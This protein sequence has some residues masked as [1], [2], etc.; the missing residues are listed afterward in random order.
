DA[1]VTRF[2]ALLAGFA[3]LLTR[4]TN[5]EEVVVGTPTAG[6][7]AP[8]SRDRL[9]YFVNPVPL[10]ITVPPGISFR[11]LTER[12]RGAVLDALDHAVPFPR[13]VEAVQPV[14]DPGRP[15]LTQAMLV[16]HQPP[17]G[18]PD[19]GGLAVADETAQTDLGGLLVRPLRLAASDSPFDLSLILAEVAGGLSGVVEY[20][21]DLFDAPAVSN[22][23]SHLTT[24]LAAV[25][26]SPDVPLETVNPLDHEARKRVLAIGDRGT[27]PYPD[28]TTVHALFS[29]QAARSP[30]AVAVVSGA[31]TMNYS[32]LDRRSGQVAALLRDRFG[33]TR[34]D[35]VAVLL[36]RDDPDLIVTFWGILKAGAAY[37]PLDPQLP[38]NRLEWLLSDASPAT[39]V[40]DATLADR[41]PDG[42]GPV[43]CRL[44]DVDW[45]GVDPAAAD[46]S[47]AGPDDLAYV[48]YTSGSTGRP[49]GVQVPHRGVCNLAE[50]FATGFGISEFD[51]VLQYASCGFD[52]WILETLPAQLRGAALYLVQP[53]AVPPGPLLVE[54]LERERITAAILAPAV[55]AALPDTKLPHLN[56]LVS[57][58]DVCPTDVVDRWAPGRHFLNAYGPTE[59]TVCATTAV[60]QPERRRPPIGGPLDNVRLYVL[61]Q[62]MRPVPEGVPGELYIGG[63]GITWGYL[64][65]PGLTAERF[66]PDPFGETPGARLYRTGDRVR[67]L[68]DGVLDFLGRVDQQVKI[69]GVRIEP[70]E[71]ESRLMEVARPREV[72]VVA[73]DRPG[74]RVG[75]AVELVAYLVADP[76][77]PTVGELRALLR[78]ELP[79]PL[80]PSAFVYLD[81][82]PRAA[83]GKLDREALPAPTL[84]DR[85]VTASGAPR[86]DLERTVAEVWAAA[87]GHETVGLRDHFFDELGGSS[88]LVAKV[89]AELSRRLGRDVPVTYL[90]EHPTVESLARRLR[91]ESNRDTPVTEPGGELP[92]QRVA[93]ARRRALARRRNQR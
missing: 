57:A 17:A 56:R 80:V 77:R 92:G 72:A 45:D 66:L 79:A 55:L 19:L 74:Q 37:L 53:E 47:G 23:T 8:D 22:L 41:L 75:E 52:A 76:P 85:G 67:W 10:R 90:F 59:I 21:P 91:Q 73:R 3:A 93:E 7:D 48:I 15:V 43:R 18:T 88:L 54:L 31:R 34:G 49:K 27:V 9:G 2:V 40:T 11:G 78:A 82:L 84:S 29:R 36:G 20:C 16:L 69:R 46:D 63:P 12:V 26:T 13:L 42:S 30:E 32:Q 58:A 35:L 68:A 86:T 60:C 71:V 24:L 44:D 64:N 81:R 70:G 1:G 62:S 87:L 14:R 89:T 4:Y 5:D 28:Q 61:D 50:S 51:R 33:V 25:V 39:V 6:R 65:R 83:S 38:G